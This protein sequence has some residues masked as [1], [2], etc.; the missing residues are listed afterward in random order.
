MDVEHHTVGLM[1]ITVKTVVPSF[2]SVAVGPIMATVAG[3]TRDGKPT[4]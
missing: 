3:H 4:T 2:L 1:N